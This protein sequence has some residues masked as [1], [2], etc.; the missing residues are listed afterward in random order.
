MLEDLKGLYQEFDAHSLLHPQ[1]VEHFM[2]NL[3]II[4]VLLVVAYMLFKLVSQFF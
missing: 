3:V 2:M 1:S 4:G